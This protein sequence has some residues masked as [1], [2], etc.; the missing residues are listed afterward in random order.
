MSLPGAATDTR[1]AHSGAAPAMP[2]AAMERLLR[3]VQADLADYAGLNDLLDAQFAGALRHDAQAMESLAGRIVAVVDQLDARRQFRVGLLARL[4]G[5]ATP[6]VPALVA[7][8]PAARRAAVQALWDRLE[9]A[10][11]DCKARNLRNARL[12]T[13]QNALLARVLHGP[14]DTLY[15]DA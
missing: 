2:R 15:A 4:T 11:Q 6:S 7:Q 8:W 1:P 10:V 5:G 12:L 14:E 3:D 13:E 9:Q